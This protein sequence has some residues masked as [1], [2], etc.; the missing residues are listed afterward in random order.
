[1]I[2]MLKNSIKQLMSGIKKRWYE[3]YADTK[4]DKI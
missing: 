2:Y 3:E 1:M 4:N